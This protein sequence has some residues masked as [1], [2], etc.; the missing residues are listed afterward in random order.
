MINVEVRK[1][2]P[3]ICWTVLSGQVMLNQFQVDVEVFSQQVHFV[4]TCM[5]MTCDGEYHV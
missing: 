3:K 2:Q 1:L 4:E 5:G